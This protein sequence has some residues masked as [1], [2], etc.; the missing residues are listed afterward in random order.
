MEVMTSAKTYFTQQFPDW[1]EAVEVTDAIVQRELFQRMKTAEPSE[2]NSA[3]LCLRCF[4]SYQIDQACRD[5]GMKFGNRNGF[6]A[7]DLLPFVLDDDGRSRQNSQYR[8]LS[9]IAL[10]SFDPAKASLGTWVNLQV[11]QHP[12]LRRFLL[13][14]GVYL[15]SD[16]AILNDTTPKQLQRIFAEIYHLTDT[17]IQFASELLKSFHAIYREERLQQ[18]LSGKLQACQP[19]TPEQLKRIA[20]DLFDRMQHPIS[21]ETVLS[22]LNAIAARL[23][24]YRIVAK[25]GTVDSVPFD[26]PEIRPLVDRAQPPQEDDEQNEFLQFYQSQFMESLDHAIAEVI[27]NMVTTLQRKRNSADQSFLTALHLFHCQGQPMGEI[28]PQVG[29][30]KQYEVTRLLKLND[31]RADIR[32]RSLANLRDRV[33]D[34][35]KFYADIDRLQHLEEKVDLILNEQLTG[36]IEEAEAETKS[37]VRN[38]PLKSLLARRLCLYL[39]SRKSNS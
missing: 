33:I 17:D 20:N 10:N 39:A 35:A 16:W 1:V 37:P 34:K 2:R 31:L 4:I 22:Q 8:S 28:A 21:S 32:Q 7:L 30:K 15:V 27:P 25:G 6:T 13:E 24:R 12:E 29:L 9:Q 23:R 14:H 38:Q 19:P 26:Q 36:V 18:R 5:L 11:K 3:E